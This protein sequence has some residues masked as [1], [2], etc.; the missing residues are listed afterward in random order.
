MT[1]PWKYLC[2]ASLTLFLTIAPPQPR[3]ANADDRY[4]WKLFSDLKVQAR[5]E[6][7]E[8]DVT[9]DTFGK[10]A[11]K[12]MLQVKLKRDRQTVKEVLLDI[13]DDEDDF[14]KAAE[15]CLWTPKGGTQ[16]RLQFK[17]KVLANA[18]PKTGQSGVEVAVVLAEPTRA[19]GWRAGMAMTNSVEKPLVTGNA[20]Q[21]GAG[22]AGFVIQSVLN[23]SA[24]TRVINAADGKQY[25]LEAGDTITQIDGTLIR[26]LDDLR[27]AMKGKEKVTL[28]V[29]DR[30]TG[31]TLTFTAQPRDGILG[32]K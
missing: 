5:A 17:S 16:A 27:A 26:S 12:P 22:G 3:R 24:A 28:K 20:P 25:S 14:K 23:G 30:T 1:K 19:G 18:V 2:L 7:A 32:V 10:V 8:G 13:L 31:K 29:L 6:S 11:G 15:G 21:L 9:M 4:T